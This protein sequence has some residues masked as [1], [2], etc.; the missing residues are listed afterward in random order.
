M[1]NV[2]TCSRFALV[3]PALVVLSGCVG[4][5]GGIPSLAQRPAERAY[6]AAA[7]PG[8]ATP[9]RFSAQPDA[10]IMQRT[11]ALRADAARADQAFSTSAGRAA[12]AVATAHDAGVGSEAWAAAT[13]ALATLDSLRSQTVLPLAE[14]DQLMADTA[15]SAAA[16]NDAQGAATFAAVA[17]A[18][19]AVA[20]LLR[21]QDVRI[22]Q[23]QREGPNTP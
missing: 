15:L 10:R 6:A 7:L 4:G 8:P 3:C 20:A 18:D 1:V 11:T 12:R 9:P 17:E 19:R 21:D 13:I 2:I 16:A 5:T 23:L 14:L 22:A